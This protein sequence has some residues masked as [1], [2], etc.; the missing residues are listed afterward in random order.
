[1]RLPRVG[2]PER[3]ERRQRKRPRTR[4]DARRTEAGRVA[5]PP[6]RRDRGR[7]D[8]GRKRVHLV[9]ARCISWA[10][11]GGRPDDADLSRYFPA[12]RWQRVRLSI[13]LCFFLRIRLRRFLISEPMRGKNLP[14]PAASG[15]TRERL[16]LVDPAL[17]HVEAGRPEPL[18]AHV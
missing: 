1:G 17:D 6:T 5:R 13:F 2:R 12:R 10:W 14:G 18:V 11:A 3:P 4:G 15:R 16:V 9:R 7:A 8:A